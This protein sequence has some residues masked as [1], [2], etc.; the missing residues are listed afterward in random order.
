MRPFNKITV[1][2]GVLFSL[3]QPALTAPAAH[4]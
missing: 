3:F 4:A 1:S 2:C